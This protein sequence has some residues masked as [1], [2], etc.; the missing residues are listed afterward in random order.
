MEPWLAA[1][2]T[3]WYQKYSWVLLV[4]ARVRDS[5]AG[6]DRMASGGYCWKVLP[7]TRA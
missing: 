1:A 4:R 3:Y 6:E 2:A 5:L 7:D